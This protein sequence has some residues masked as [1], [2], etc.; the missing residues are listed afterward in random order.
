VTEDYPELVEKWEEI[1]GH[2]NIIIVEPR[3]EQKLKGPVHVHVVSKG[4]ARTGE[5][6]DKRG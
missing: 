6:R 2:C 1:T 3:E 5:D 4:G